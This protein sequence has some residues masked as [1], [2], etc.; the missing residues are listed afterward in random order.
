[1]PE[2]RYGV[3][4]HQQTGHKPGKYL[5]CKICRLAEGK[6]AESLQMKIILVFQCANLSTPTSTR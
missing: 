2:M 4:G 3:T 1:M 6:G 5:S